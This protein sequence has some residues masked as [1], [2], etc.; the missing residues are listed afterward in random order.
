M[1]AP[2][3]AT[4]FV[5][6]LRSAM[7][8]APSLVRAVEAATDATPGS[9]TLGPSAAGKDMSH[10]EMF[11]IVFMSKAAEHT[12]NP[13]WIPPGALCWYIIP[14]TK[15]GYKE[16]IAFTKRGMNTIPFV[17]HMSVCAGNGNMVDERCPAGDRWPDYGKDPAKAKC[18][19]CRPS[20]WYAKYERW[21]DILGPG[22]HAA[23][24]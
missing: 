10:L 1:T 9:L 17:T 5:A 19:W 6:N 21:V 12:N 16:E 11:R 22:T 7:A 15:E 4:E 24:K 2:T 14:G 8:G 13:A 20:V 3:L 23:R 18:R